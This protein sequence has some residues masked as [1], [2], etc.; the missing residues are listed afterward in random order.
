MSLCKYKEIFG[1]P[2]EGVHSY[3]LFGIAIVDVVFT[4]ILAYILT[5]VFFR[6]KFWTILVFL[7]ILGEIFHLLFCVET[8]ITN[9]F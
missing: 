4:I 5:L 1:K 9:L 3:R 6:N 2:G 7:L 8:P